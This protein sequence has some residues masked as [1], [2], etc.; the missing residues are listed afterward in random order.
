M[1]FTD[2]KCSRQGIVLLFVKWHR[3]VESTV[4]AEH[5]SPIIYSFNAQINQYCIGHVLR[6]NA[7]LCE[8]CL[9]DLQAPLYR[10]KLQDNEQHVTFLHESA[11]LSTASSLMP[12]FPACLLP[13][14]SICCSLV[15]TAA[16]P[17]QSLSGGSERWKE[18]WR[19]G[20]T[21]D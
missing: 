1:V 10:P 7:P 4:K 12:T 5:K 20:T 9:W 17:S 16:V 11:H 6:W 21:D 3:V 2:L 19:A 8:V 18:S 15:V 13:V 14:C